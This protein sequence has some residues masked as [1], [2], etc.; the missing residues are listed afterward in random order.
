MAREG[1]SKRICLASNIVMRLRL[2][3]GYLYVYTRY[4]VEEVHLSW[5][6]FKAYVRIM[7]VLTFPHTFYGTS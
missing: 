5:W 7:H 2:E 6:I 1:R 3:P 4:V